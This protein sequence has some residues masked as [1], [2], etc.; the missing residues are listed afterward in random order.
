MHDAL[1]NIVELFEFSDASMRMELLVGFGDTLPPLDADAAALRD[2]GEHLVHECQSPV[3][4]FP[5]IDEAN[6]LHI[7]TDVPREAAVARGFVGLLREAF[8][9]ESARVLDSTPQDLL[10]ACRIALQLTMRRQRGLRA[11]YE[12]LLKVR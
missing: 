11:I 1:S 10:D 2:A 3:F 8:D 7:H 4:F 5:R 12:R 9:G 6:V